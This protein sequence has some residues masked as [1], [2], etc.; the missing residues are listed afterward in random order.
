MYSPIPVARATLSRLVKCRED[1][2]VASE[3]IF[4]EHGHTKMDVTIQSAEDL[5]FM[6]APVV[7][8]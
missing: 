1:L 4:A 2:K 8:I 5:K 6:H 3:E 7:H